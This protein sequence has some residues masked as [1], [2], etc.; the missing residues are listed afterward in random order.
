M[1]DL[2]RSLTILKYN[3]ATNFEFI[4]EKILKKKNVLGPFHV[5]SFLSSYGKFLLKYLKIKIS[6]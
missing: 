5:I 6:K 1:T 4:H 3:N 2:V